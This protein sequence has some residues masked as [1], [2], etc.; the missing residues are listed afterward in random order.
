MT[1]ARV[2]LYWTHLLNYGHDHYH[3]R[4]DLMLE[5]QP[6]RQKWQS[7]IMEIHL[8]LESIA[9]RAGD[10]RS[11]EL[12]WRQTSKGRFPESEARTI[13]VGFSSDDRW[14]PQLQSA[15]TLFTALLNSAGETSGRSGGRP[16]LKL[17]SRTAPKGP[18]ELPSG[19]LICATARR[20]WSLDSQWRPEK[21]I[22][23][24]GFYSTP[25]ISLAMIPLIPPKSNG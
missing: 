16:R 6:R 23:P 2:A 14:S 3:L 15:H 7:E 11:P 25:G 24:S 10:D 5:K 19:P 4:A 8:R 20:R 12:I 17:P 21:F 13:E 1:C 9:R 22:E 18:A